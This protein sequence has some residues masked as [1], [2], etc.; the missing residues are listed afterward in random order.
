MSGYPGQLAAG[1]GPSGI[2]TI[3]L[4][5]NSYFGFAP[6]YSLGIICTMSP[7]ASMNYSVQVTGDPRPSS[8][9]NWNFHDILVALSSSANGNI[10]FP[11]TGV[12]VLVSAYG[13]GS[14]NLA[15]VQ[16]P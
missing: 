14:V 15:V 13:S 9:G 5:A 3:N 10:N 6:S 16:W 2:V 11:V 8:D 4:P 1:P 7:G 12:R